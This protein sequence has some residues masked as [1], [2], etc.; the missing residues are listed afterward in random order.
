M[1]AA[2]DDREESAEEERRR[3]RW[4]VGRT[5]QDGGRAVSKIVI[6]R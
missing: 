4:Y 2:A 5:G 1:L 3:R 6:T